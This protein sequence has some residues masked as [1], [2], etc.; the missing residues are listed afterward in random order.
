VD[1]GI[2]VV[3]FVPSWK[4]LRLDGTCLE[5]EG[6]APDITVQT[7]PEDFEKTDPVVEAALRL[8]RG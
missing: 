8:L 1:L 4:D 6:F 2:G 5:G 3:A 7:R